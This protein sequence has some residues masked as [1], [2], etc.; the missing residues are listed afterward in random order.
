MKR[1]NA[2]LYRKDFTAGP[3]RTCTPLGESSPVEA[4]GKNVNAPKMKRATTSP[5]A[6]RRTQPSRTSSTPMPSHSVTR[7]AHQRARSHSVRSCRRAASERVR[8]DIVS[9]ERT[10]SPP[11]AGRRAYQLWR[12]GSG[13]SRWIVGT[14]PGSRS[15]PSRH[16]SL[17]SSTVSLLL[18]WSR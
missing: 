15:R 1:N 10:V 5:R 13:S 3:Q 11:A 14:S 4:A 18:S 8:L 9:G 7:G 6:S 17:E 16:T 2:D 12:S